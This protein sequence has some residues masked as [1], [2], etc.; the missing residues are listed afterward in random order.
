LSDA[1]TFLAGDSEMAL[2]IRAHDWAR[3]PL[4]P[5]VP[6]TRLDRMRILVVDDDPE[7]LELFSL[8]F[9]RHGAEV[10]V[11]RTAADALAQ[12]AQHRPDV[13]VCDIEMPG[14]DGYSLIRR[15]RTLAVDGTAGVPAVAVTAYGA[16][17]GPRP[18]P[19]S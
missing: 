7:A 3:T 16:V 6:A 17:G 19:A 12:L 8:L 10:A 18:L 2:R 14:E 9:T 1:E 11:A 15:V 5:A 4:G 13:L